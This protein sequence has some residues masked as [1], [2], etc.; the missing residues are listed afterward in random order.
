[1]RKEVGIIIKSKEPNIQFEPVRNSYIA[2]IYHPVTV[3]SNMEPNAS[4]NKAF[5][6]TSTKFN[7]YFGKYRQHQPK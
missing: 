4:T 5:S 1:M 6:S 3:S 2:I 7:P